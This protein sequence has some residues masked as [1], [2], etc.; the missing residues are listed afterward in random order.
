L[1]GMKGETT[2]EECY[3]YWYSRI[4]DG[5]YHYIHYA[6]NDMISTQKPVEMSYTWNHPD[7][8]EVTV[9]CLGIR[10]EDG[11]GRVC[12]SGYH[13]EINEV[14]SKK[15]L[16][17]AGSIIFEYNE[18]NHSVYFHNERGVLA[19]TVEKEENFPECWLK[20][21][22]VHP[23]FVNRFK[24]VFTKIQEQPEI[25]GEEF[26]LL[27]KDGTYDWF[28][29]KTKVFGKDEQDADMLIAIMD[30]AS[31]ERAAE[32][33]Q[34]RM[35]DFYKASLS[36]KIAYME[37]DMESHHILD[38]GG[39]WSVYKDEY[40]GRDH[41]YKEIL[42]KYIEDMIHP[43]D[44]AA[45]EAFFDD[46]LHQQMIKDKKY[47]SKLQ[48]RRLLDGRMQWMEITGHMFQEQFTENLYA[49]LYLK[50]IDA[51]KCQALEHEE[52]A[53]RDPLTGVF[54][55]RA[56]ET[57]VVKHIFSS[58]SQASTLIMLDLDNFK[59]IND[60]YGHVEGDRVLKQLADVL[61]TTF[62]RKDLLGRHGGD[63][64]LIFL[65][66]VTDKE[67]INRRLDEFRSAFAKVNQYGS[68]CSV[69]ITLVDPKDF[70]YSEVL[71]KADVALY[72][73]K[74]K[75]KNTY[76]YYEGE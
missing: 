67:V 76:S 13:R 19:G 10:V 5:Y 37:I 60:T 36:E 22:M 56:F 32:L 27:T 29:L 26:L 16:P 50:N 40:M 49:L 11:D 58:A 68:T 62:R 46:K 64:F 23:H 39:L 42:T 71:R 43:D 65:K 20:A 4:Q 48:Y 33:Q 44:R 21:G 70:S 7:K 63:E 72:Q 74:E 59:S 9:R 2:P 6:I 45:Y 14:D 57:E 75:G 73:S 1:L 54:N 24:Q 34:M 28:R 25:L 69:G 3:L 18:K 15:F 17:E 66:N 30:P 53:T 31:Q 61:M 12:L 47:T 52:A 41:D 38:A 55:R 8:G 51:E 35:Q